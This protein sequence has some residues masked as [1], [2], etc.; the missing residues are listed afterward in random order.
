MK[1][2]LKRVT[3]KVLRL[4]MLIDLNGM[5]DYQSIG[6]VRKIPLKADRPHPRNRTAGRSAA[7]RN[8]TAGRSAANR[9][10]TADRSA[11]EDSALS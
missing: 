3:D 10:R 11:G 2:L 5:W 1:L 6:A 4:W 9:N 7:N 8:R